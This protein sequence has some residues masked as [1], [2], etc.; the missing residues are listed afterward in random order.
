MANTRVDIDALRQLIVDAA[1]DPALAE[2]VLHCDPDTLLDTLI[3]FSSVIVL[4]VIVAV[5]DTYRIAV[6]KPM[7][8]Q[9]LTGGATLH[10]LARMIEAAR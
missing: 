10:K 8:V 5:E 4:G 1:P 7:I 2:P 6:T 3:P 9:A